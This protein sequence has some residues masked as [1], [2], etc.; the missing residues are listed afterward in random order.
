M[1]T[2]VF[3]KASVNCRADKTTSGRWPGWVSALS[4]AGTIALIIETA[5]LLA[6][7]LIVVILLAEIRIRLW[8]RI[9]IRTRLRI[10][11]PDASATSTIKLA[12]CPNTLR[13]VVIIILA[14]VRMAVIK[15]SRMI[16]FS[17]TKRRRSIAD[18]RSDRGIISR[19]IL[20]TSDEA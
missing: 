14:V 12:P 15:S 3:L 4:C 9:W 6:L 1:P 16:A 18:T 13:V 20:I 5:R 7:I 17:V 11:T 19:C 2:A 10:S 8:L